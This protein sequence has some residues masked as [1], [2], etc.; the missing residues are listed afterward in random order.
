MITR[1]N[2]ESFEQK[3][4]LVDSV[5]CKINGKCLFKALENHFTHS[6]PTLASS[7]LV[8]RGKE[9]SLTTYGHH[10]ADFCL[11]YIWFTAS[12]LKVVSVFVLGWG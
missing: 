7:Y 2:K 11:D 3:N 6:T 8:V 10:P 9:P 12:M 5:T 4:K 1:W